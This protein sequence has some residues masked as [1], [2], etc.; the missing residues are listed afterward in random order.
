L[1]YGAQGVWMGLVIGLGFAA[2]VLLWRY[3]VV[4]GRTTARLQ[5]HQ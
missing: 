4:L 1:G 2:V 5:G 3:W